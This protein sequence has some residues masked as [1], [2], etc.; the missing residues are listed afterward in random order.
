MHGH[1]PCVLWLMHVL[2]RLALA[3]HPRSGSLTHWNTAHG[4]CDQVGQLT[5]KCQGKCQ[6]HSC[7]LY[8]EP[9]S[10]NTTPNSPALMLLPWVSHLGLSLVLIPA[11]GTGLQG[12]GKRAHSTCDLHQVV[13][14]QV[15]QRV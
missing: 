7:T 6:L 12:R 9:P 11:E 13:V 8:L 15:K 10:Q 1:V 4:S 2:T 5:L 14:Y 3:V